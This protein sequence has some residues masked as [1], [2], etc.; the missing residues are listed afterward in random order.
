M[1]NI[2][3]T[4]RYKMGCL[5]IRFASSS[6]FGFG[7]NCYHAIKNR[8]I[9]HYMIHRLGK[10][11]YHFDEIFDTVGRWYSYKQ[12]LREKEIRVLRRINMEKMAEIADKNDMEQWEVRAIIERDTGLDT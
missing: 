8:F 2:A 4:L 10:K 3:V 9:G 11:G 6:L 12:Y 1:R 5:V 7:F